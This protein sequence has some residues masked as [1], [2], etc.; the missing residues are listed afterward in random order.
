MERED[1]KRRRLLAPAPV[2]DASSQTT[3][4]PYVL[5]NR[6]ERI[7]S[8]QPRPS[9]PNHE[10]VDHSVQQIGLSP[11][12]NVD[13]QGTTSLVRE[14]HRLNRQVSACAIVFGLL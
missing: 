2:L 6:S 9:L 8:I 5:P 1:R 3:T 14:S 13:V 10:L 4:H 12:R 7:A 11:G